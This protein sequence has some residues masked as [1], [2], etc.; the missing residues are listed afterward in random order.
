M[1]IKSQYDDLSTFD[2]VAI[3]SIIPVV[4]QPEI[5][6]RRLGRVSMGRS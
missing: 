1:E 6:P 2:G 4:R 5:V 3:L